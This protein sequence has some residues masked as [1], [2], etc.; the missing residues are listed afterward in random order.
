MS[1]VRAT[2]SV[3]TGVVWYSTGQKYSLCYQKVHANRVRVIR[4]H[5]CI[6][7]RTF[8]RAKKIH[9]R[10]PRVYVMRVRVDEVLLYIYCQSLFIYFLK[11]AEI[12]L[13]YITWLSVA[14]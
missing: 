12:T 7:P 6:K 11:N 8:D 1:P 9:P 3:L 10:N 14:L 13:H 5:L 4:R 2:P